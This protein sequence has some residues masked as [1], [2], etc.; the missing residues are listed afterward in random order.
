MFVRG[1]KEQFDAWSGWHFFGPYF[2]CDFIGPVW[3]V[4][5]VAGWELCDLVFSLYYNSAWRLRYLRLDGP[6]DLLDGI[7]DRRGASWGDIVLGF[8]AVLIWIYK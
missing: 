7:F 5:A 3:T 6:T 8:I 1:F 2:L 4:I